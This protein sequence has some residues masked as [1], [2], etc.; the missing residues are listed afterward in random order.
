MDALD[1]RS[2]QT[3]G[4][5]WLDHEPF[6][7]AIAVVGSTPEKVIDQKEDPAEMGQACALGLTAHDPYRI[8]GSLADR[9]SSDALEGYGSVFQYLLAV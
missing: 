3:V 4:T 7:D 6:R 8:A 5:C 2:N 1:Y 9:K